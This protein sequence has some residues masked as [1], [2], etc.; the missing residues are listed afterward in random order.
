MPRVTAATRSAST[1][2]TKDVLFAGD[3]P[4]LMTSTD[5]SYEIGLS[6]RIEEA[7]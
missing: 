6:S 5:G 1:T 2:K 4:L 7:V 3:S